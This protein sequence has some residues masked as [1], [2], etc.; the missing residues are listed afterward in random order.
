MS[1][2]DAKEKVRQKKIKARELIESILTRRKDTENLNSYISIFKETA[3]SKAEDLDK[4]IEQ[5]EQPELTGL[6]LSLK[7]DLCWAQ[8]KTTA[9]ASAL[10][11]YFP[12]FSSAPAEKLHN[13]GA[14]VIGKN[15]LD[16]W[17][18]GTTTRTSSYGV[19]LNP[20]DQS[21]VAGDG[22]AAAVASGSAHLGLGSDTG[23]GVRRSAS[24]CGVLGLR[25]TPGR[26]SRHGL[27]NFSPSFSQV[28]VLARKPE[29]L[30]LALD[31]ISGVDSRDA[32]TSAGPSQY[33]KDIP[34]KGLIAAYPREIFEQLDQEHAKI[35]QET[36]DLFSQTGITFEEVELRDFSLGVQAYYIIA[37]AEASSSL[38]RYDGIRFGSAYPA[39][40]LDEWYFRTRSQTFGVE[41]RRRSVMGTAYLNEQNYQRYYSKALQVRS[42][43]KEE[44]FKALKGRHL[45]ILPAVP[46]VAPGLEDQSHFLNEYQQ[47]CYCSPVSLAGLP[48]LSVPAGRLEHLPLGLQLVGIPF[49]EN[50]LIEVARRAG[51]ETAEFP[52]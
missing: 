33:I 48:A 31:E 14:V 2:F 8:G 50:L 32:S 10:D 29:D 18:M 38:S 39:D 13:S 35:L 11:N 40:E 43:V 52:S 16:Q 49:S 25:P 23:G 36:I 41:A 20:W 46:S 12:S 28:G 27:I 24:Y 51:I 30:S 37:S 15:N 17:S 7:D 19:T 21:R 45:L 44:L 6:A 34:E 26:V 4:K 22:A 9:G 1:A 47:D 3:L 42:M 5:G